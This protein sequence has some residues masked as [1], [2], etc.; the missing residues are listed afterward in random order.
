MKEGKYSF[1]SKEQADKKIDA[2]GLDEDGN[3]THSHTI[4]RIGHL[5]EVEA[6]LDID[7]EVI[8]EAV[9]STD[10]CVDVMWSDL[11]KHPFGWSTY[12]VDVTGNGVHRFAGIDYQENKI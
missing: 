6:V 3:V 10:Y 4:V 1:T 2:L 12:A 5:T 9:L 7:G 11:D 8:T